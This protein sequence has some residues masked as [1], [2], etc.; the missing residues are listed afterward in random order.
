MAL[1][2]SALSGL[3]DAVRAGDGTDVL[4]DSS[5]A[6]GRAANQTECDLDETR[7]PV[8]ALRAPSRHAGPR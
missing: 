1:S 5:R 2:Q 6:T 8:R 4:R 7:D 3:L